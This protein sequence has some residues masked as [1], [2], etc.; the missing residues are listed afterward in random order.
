MNGS[1]GAAGAGRQAGPA[2]VARRFLG[3]VGCLLVIFVA[4]GVLRWRG[5]DSWRRVSE[6]GVIR[7]GYAVEAPYAMAD[8]EGR[9]TGQLPEIARR[10][11]EGLGVVRVEWGLT[12]FASLADEL[13]AGRF[14]VVAAGLFVTT[15]RA[16]H[17]S[18][19]RP[20]FEVKPGLLVKAGNPLGLHSYADVTAQP[21][22]RVAVLAGSVEADLLREVGMGQ[23][24]LVEVPDGPA[25]RALVAVGRVDGL[26]LSRPTVR[27]MAEKLGGGALEEATPFAGPDAAGGRVA[28]A[29]HPRDRA[30][31]AAWDRELG[32]FMEEP[33]YREI[34]ER[35]G[36]EPWKNAEAG[37]GRR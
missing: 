29:F 24:R 14:D 10:V 33:E 23:G 15:E 37:N 19:S 20:V 7:I 3:A 28:F 31:R 18:F 17:M 13:E 26:A 34:A 5:D 1:G 21:E 30:L 2:R 36:F 4:V 8:A 35:F 27:W 9:V 6:A 11:A 32:A 12:E 22:V 25:G 16:K